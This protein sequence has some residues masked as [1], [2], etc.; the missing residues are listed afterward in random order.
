[1]TKE[2]LPAHEANTL[3]SRRAF[4]QTDTDWEAKLIRATLGSRSFGAGRLTLPVN[5]SRAL[6]VICSV[7]GSLTGQAHDPLNN[8]L[9][10]APRPSAR[11]SCRTTMPDP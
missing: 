2:R 7:K 1:M 9:R 6:R 5:R 3:A 4:P 10:S 8:S 11:A